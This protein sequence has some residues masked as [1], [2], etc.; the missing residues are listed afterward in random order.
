MDPKIVL[1]KIYL[2]MGLHKLV[3]CEVSTEVPV[4]EVSTEVP[5]SVSEY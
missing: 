5:V 1:E 2:K 3:V 4:S